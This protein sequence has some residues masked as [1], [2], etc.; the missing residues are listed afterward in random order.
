MS[1]VRPVVRF[2]G[3][4]HKADNDHLAVEE[5]LQI[6]LAGEDV[7]VTMRTPGHDDELAAGFLFTE[8]VIAGKRHIESISPCPDENGL[9]SPNIINVFPT[10]RGLLEPGRWG[11][12]FYASSSCGLCGKVSIEQVTTH[13]GSVNGSFKVGPDV[14]YSLPEKLRE[15]QGTFDLTGGIHAAGL[16]DQDGNLVVLREDVGRH[17]AVDKVIGYALLND[18]LPLDHFILLV[19]SRASFEIT[20]KALAAGIPVLAAVSAPSTLAVDLARDSGMTLVGFLRQGRLN[21]YA[22]EERVWRQ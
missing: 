6:R 12:N 22:G 5:P 13:T 15:G 17:N 8:G 14:L 2:S 16:F 7:A 1:G 10:E 18:M 4:Q 3:Q 20:Q 21:I 19:S 9:P 11:R